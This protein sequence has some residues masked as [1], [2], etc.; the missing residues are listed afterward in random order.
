MSSGVE[1]KK[2]GGSGIVVV[3]V[4]RRRYPQIARH[5]ERQLTG[6]N[7]RKWGRIWIDPRKSAKHERRKDA[8]WTEGPS[9]RGMPHGNRDE[10]PGAMFICETQEVSDVE[11]CCATQNQDF[12][13]DLYAALLKEL[14]KKMGWWQ[15]RFRFV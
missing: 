4:K 6:A 10:C 11:V 8:M 12:G 7:A 13:R 9:T 2:Q 5:W 1:A 15:V 3:T 14:G